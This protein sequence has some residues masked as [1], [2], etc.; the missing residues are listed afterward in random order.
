M[1][2]TFSFGDYIYTAESR[3]WSGHPALE[4]LRG[5]L[6][7]AETRALGLLDQFSQLQE[8]FCE[9]EYERDPEQLLPYWNNPWLPPLDAI[10]LMGHL[11]IRRPAIYLEVGSGNSTKFARWIIERLKLPTKITSV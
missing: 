1:T 6:N 11:T 10:S 4:G 9:I 2:N 3:D 8:V 5:H 7:S